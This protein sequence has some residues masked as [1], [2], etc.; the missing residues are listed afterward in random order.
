MVKKAL[1]TSSD[2]YYEVEK[3]LDRKEVNGVLLYKIKWKGYPLS[4]SSWE[5]LEHLDTVEDLVDEYNLQ[6][7]AKAKPSLSAPSKVVEIQAAYEHQAQVLWRV[8]LADG[9]I[10]ERQLH[11]LRTEVPDLVIDYLFARLKFV[12]AK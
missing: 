2:T 7:S 5:P 4:A 1:A 3:I 6:H 10:E 8:K 12:E 11:Q 9:T